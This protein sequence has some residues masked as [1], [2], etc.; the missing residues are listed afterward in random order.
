MTKTKIRREIAARKKSFQGL[1]LLSELIVK[2]FQDLELFQQAKTVGAYMPLSDEPDIH[3]LFDLPGKRFFIPAFDEAF[4]VYR[5]AELTEN[6][7]P[8]KFG[9]LEPVEPVWAGNLD[10]ILVPGTA[11]D[12]GGNRLGRGGGFY[13]RILAEHSGAV[14]IGLCF[15][16][17]LVDF[18]PAEPHDRPAAW[19]VTESQVLEV[20]EER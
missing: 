17:Q 15:D 18:L 9:I 11:F 19:I 12:R 1:E 5:M 13:D 6:L 10:L 20:C 14:P 8:G 2:K 7:K 16:F 4:G 3:P